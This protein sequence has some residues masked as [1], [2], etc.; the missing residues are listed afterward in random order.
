MREF[1]HFSTVGD[2]TSVDILWE[3]TNTEVRGLGTANDFRDWKS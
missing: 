1:G 3:E 2:E